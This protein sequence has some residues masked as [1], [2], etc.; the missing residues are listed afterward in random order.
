MSP[1]SGY[2]RAADAS[3]SASTPFPK[4][5]PRS[6]P[7][8]AAFLPTPL[9]DR[10]RSRRPSE[11]PLPLACPRATLAPL[12]ARS[13]PAGKRTPPAARG[14]DGPSILPAGRDAERRIEVARA[15]AR[16]RRSGLNRNRQPLP[17]ASH[18]L[19]PY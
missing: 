16:P 10:A 9:G 5:S 17:G 13:L 4:S 14:F 3:S 8:E 6:S 2:G 15:F 18:S 11:R 7:P 12:A 1:S 19:L